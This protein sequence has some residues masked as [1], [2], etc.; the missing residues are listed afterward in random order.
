MKFWICAGYGRD[1]DLSNLRGAEFI[2]VDFRAYWPSV[3]EELAGWL[4]VAMVDEQEAIELSLESCWNAL[5]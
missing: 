4:L 3:E 5:F 2:R 1:W